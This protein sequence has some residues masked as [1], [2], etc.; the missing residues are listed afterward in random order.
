VRYLNRSFTEQ[1]GYTMDD[2]PTLDSWFARAYPM[3][4]TAESGDSLAGKD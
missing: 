1:F 3:S 4:S 2:I